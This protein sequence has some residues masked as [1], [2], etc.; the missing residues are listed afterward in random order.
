MQSH[1]GVPG[2]RASTCE[3]GNGDTIQPITPSV[4][5][6]LQTGYILKNN[7]NVQTSFEWQISNRF[8]YAEAN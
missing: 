2:I 8:T 3:F 1:S 7:I 4:V 5:W 6:M